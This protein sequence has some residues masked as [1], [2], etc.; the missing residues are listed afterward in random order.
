MIVSLPHSFYSFFNS[1][2]WVHTQRRQY[3]LLLD[4]KKSSMTQDKIDS[5]N[6]VG[7]VWVA[8]QSDSDDDDDADSSCGA[9]KTKSQEGV[10]QSNL[11]SAESDK[12]DENDTSKWPRV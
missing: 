2:T 11:K 1:R 5:L 7:F 10:N 4:G 8:R 3:K 12:D 6:A 9:N